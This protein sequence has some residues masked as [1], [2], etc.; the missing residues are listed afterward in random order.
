MLCLFI[1]VGK[2][3]KEKKKKKVGRPKSGSIIVSAIALLLLFPPLLRL[4]NQTQLPQRLLSPFFFPC[5]QTHPVERSPSSQARRPSI[6]RLCDFTPGVLIVT[7]AYST[8]GERRGPRVGERHFDLWPESE[9]VTGFTR[10][11]AQ[12]SGERYEEQL[13]LCRERGRNKAAPQAHKRSAAPSNAREL[14]KD[15]QQVRNEF[16]LALPCPALSC[17]VLSCPPSRLG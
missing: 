8:Q 7:H 10:S 11:H 12:L 2:K 13:A 4:G 16:T 5:E 6:A 3:R 15:D 17:P 14:K 9:H 1:C